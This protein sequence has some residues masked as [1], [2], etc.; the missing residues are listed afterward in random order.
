MTDVNPARCQ[1]DEIK[2]KSCCLNGDSNEVNRQKRVTG[3]EKK[4]TS[5]KAS[6]S[7]TCNTALNVLECNV[8]RIIGLSRSNCG[9]CNGDRA[10][11]LTDGVIKSKT[12]LDNEIDE[13]KNS[14]SEEESAKCSFK[15]RS[16]EMDENNN[17]ID[18]TI[19]KNTSS[20]MYS[21]LF[22]KLS[23]MDYQLLINRGWRRSGNL[24]YL[25][26]NKDSCCPAIPIRLHVKS[27]QISKGQKRV[28][29]RF[30]DSF[31][32]S[33]NN[34]SS[35]QNWKNN[36]NPHNSIQ[37][38]K[39]Q[40]HWWQNLDFQT[41]LQLIIQQSGILDTIQQNCYK[42]VNDYL[43]Q[44]SHEKWYPIMDDENKTA[45]KK[46][47]TFKLSKVS[48]P[49]TEI[50]GELKK[51]VFTFKASTNVCP[52]IHGKSKGN[53]DKDLLAQNILQKLTSDSN[54]LSPSCSHN[55]KCGSIQ[56]H[57]QSGHII[58]PLLVTAAAKDG[59]TPSID[60]HLSTDIPIDFENTC[61]KDSYH[62]NE[63]SEKTK[64]GKDNVI[65]DFLKTIGC[66]DSILPPYRL[67]VKS[68]PSSISACQPEVHQL[69][70]KYQHAIHNDPNP[71][72]KPVDI[73]NSRKRKETCHENIVD[74]PCTEQECHN[75][76]GQTFD[77]KSTSEEMYDDAIVGESVKYSKPMTLTDIKNHYPNL[78]LE[79]YEN[80]YKSYQAF[81][82]FLCSSPFPTDSST[83]SMHTEN[84]KFQ[85][86]ENGYDPHIPYGCYHQQYRINDKYLFA[87]GVIDVLP[88]CVSSVYA[89]YDPDLSL[90]LNLGKV[91]AMR[92]IEW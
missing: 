23:P 17:Y 37:H 38:S 61:P 75:Q 48:K 24:L 21:L 18:E 84:D 69:F 57:K 86:D 25:P 41:S 22:D 81:Y 92:E 63:K 16:K 54:I 51:Y 58:I 43:L 72:T 7:P 60:C 29:K 6:V 2:E 9:Y 53:V 26:K 14:N 45:L 49:K 42:V 70:A 12:L 78:K 90:K 4:C 59:S 68:V 30:S 3:T 35:D 67:T 47:C 31:T 71:F 66:N 82:E 62:S 87:V 11:I 5:D 34:H 1:D 56:F 13:A 20:K 8:T 80:I 65:G 73:R 79:H 27:F 77:C 40:N 44:P 15:A 83:L 88:N 64:P 39:V 32:N 50:K 28:W 74:P 85:L 46:L 19:T 91:T 10:H 52:A 36:V 76:N 89:F 55:L 33:N